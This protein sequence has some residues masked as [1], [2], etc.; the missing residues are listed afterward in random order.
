M[1][2]KLVSLP[3]FALF[4]LIK[5]NNCVLWALGGKAT[6]FFYEVQKDIF[7][8][9]L[10]SLVTQASYLLIFFYGTWHHITQTWTITDAPQ[11]YA[12]QS[13]KQKEKNPF[14]VAAA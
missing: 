3:L 13:N 7:L 6:V 2:I 4:N 12:L 11:P 10:V 1:N 8:L 9:L 14:D 5:Y